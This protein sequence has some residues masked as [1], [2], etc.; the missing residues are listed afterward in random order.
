LLTIYPQ[1]LHIATPF[2]N[3]KKKSYMTH[4]LENIIMFTSLALFLVVLSILVISLLVDV[5]TAAVKL[6]RKIQAKH[7]VEKM[8]V[9]KYVILSSNI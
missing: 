4:T 2:L 5:I 1:G 7:E 8:P 3:I 6:S 9:R